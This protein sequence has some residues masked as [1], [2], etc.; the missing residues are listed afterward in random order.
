M[1]KNGNKTELLHPKFVPFITFNDKFNQNDEDE[2][3]DDLKRVVC[4]Y[5]DN[6]PK[7]CNSIAGKDKI[8]VVQI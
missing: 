2:A 7:Q 8:N 5:L 6:T 3:V 1:S 4:K